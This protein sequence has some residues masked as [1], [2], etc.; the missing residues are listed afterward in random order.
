VAKQLSREDARRKKD[1][2]AEFM[3]R[4]GQP[5]R[6]DEFRDMNVEDY[7]EGKG[8]RLSNPA[9][10]RR[11]TTMSNGTTSKTDLQDQMGRAIETLEDAYQPETPREDLAEAIGKALDILRGD[12]EED[13]DETDED[14]DLD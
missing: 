13:D 1:Q 5:D 6:A 4:I 12:E 11:T 9:F 7:A 2:A 10:N 3:E 8:V 14:D